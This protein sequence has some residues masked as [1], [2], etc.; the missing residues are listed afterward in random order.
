MQTDSQQSKAE[1]H[2]I[3]RF[4]TFTQHVCIAF[5]MT[6][7]I[8]FSVAGTAMITAVLLDG[9]IRYYSPPQLLGLC[10][11]VAIVGAVLYAKRLD[12]PIR[13]KEKGEAPRGEP[14]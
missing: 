2:F 5:M 4:I 6:V 1:S 8:F 9:F 10:I 7:I 11:A 3:D 12:S 14:T 13:S